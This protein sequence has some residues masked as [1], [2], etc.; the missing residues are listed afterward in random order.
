MWRLVFAAPGRLVGPGQLGE[1][2]TD[3]LRTKCWKMREK[4]LGSTLLLNTRLG[5]L[6]FSMFPEPGSSTG[7]ALWAVTIL[8]KATRENRGEGPAQAWGHI[9]EVQRHNFTTAVITEDHKN[10]GGQGKL[11]ELCWSLL[12]CLPRTFL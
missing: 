4:S 10:C 8:L 1:K 11:W 12:Q 3:E 2:E 5:R 6:P 9:A 7:E